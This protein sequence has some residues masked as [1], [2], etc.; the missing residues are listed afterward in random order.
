VITATAAELIREI[1]HSPHEGLAFHCPEELN[2][3]HGPRHIREVS[4]H[5]ADYE[6]TKKSTHFS[7]T[8]C[9]NL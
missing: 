5:Q 1:K 9:R 6:Y 7:K 3:L 8:C 4:V 2:T